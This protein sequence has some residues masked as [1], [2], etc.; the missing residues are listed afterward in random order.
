MDKNRYRGIYVT[1]NDYTRVVLND[2]K[3]G[4]YIH[5]NYIKGAP[6]VC[7]FICTQVSL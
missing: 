4:D 3:G 6:L 7:T 5:A 1:C 2:G